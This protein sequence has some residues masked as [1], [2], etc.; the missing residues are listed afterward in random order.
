[1]EDCGAN[2]APQRLTLVI[3]SVAVSVAV[4]LFAIVRLAT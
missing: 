3:V 2:P 1:V 4:S